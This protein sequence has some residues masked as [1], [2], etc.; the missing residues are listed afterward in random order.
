MTDQ[1]SR[2]R[3]TKSLNRRSPLNRQAKAHLLHPVVNDQVYLVQLLRQALEAQRDNLD[4]L[5]QVEEVVEQLES[6]DQQAATRLLREQLES[7]DNLNREE[8]EQ[9]LLEVA[10][11]YLERD[12]RPESVRARATQ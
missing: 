7:L 12:Y 8:A 4:D 5:E 9:E 6:A 2:L 3:Q 11:E 10:Q 1:L